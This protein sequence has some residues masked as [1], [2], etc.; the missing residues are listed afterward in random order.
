MFNVRA[1]T[2]EAAP[3]RAPAP[4]AAF[5]L[6]DF[7]VPQSLSSWIGSDKQCGEHATSSARLACF[8]LFYKN[9]QFRVVTILAA[10]QVFLAAPLPAIL[11][12]RW[13]PVRTDPALG[14]DGAVS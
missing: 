9:A 8:V 11:F 3:E 5:S 13:E 7:N 10:L 14:L 4:S 2:N 6:C 12:A 1:R